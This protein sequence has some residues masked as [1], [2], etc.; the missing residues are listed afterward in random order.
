[1]ATDCMDCTDSDGAWLYGGKAW[2]AE[3]RERKL[4]DGADR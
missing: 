1:M 2:A 3:G 4:L